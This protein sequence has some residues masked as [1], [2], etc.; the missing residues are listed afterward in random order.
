MGTKGGM[1]PNIEHPERETVCELAEQLMCDYESDIERAY[2]REDG[3][4]KI[5]FGATFKPKEGG[6]EVTVDMSFTA[7]KIKDKASKVI[8]KQQPGLF[9]S[10]KGADDAEGKKDTPGTTEKGTG[11]APANT[12]DDSTDASKQY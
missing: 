3:A 7:E 2:N 9:D 1:M 8:D 10:K 6:I 5:A 11:E 4:F 12:P